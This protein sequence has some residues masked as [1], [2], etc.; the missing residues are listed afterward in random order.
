MSL[1][2]GIGKGLEGA[3]QAIGAGLAQYARMLQAEDFE[4]MR[5]A[6]MEKRWAIEDARYARREARDEQRYKDT[7]ERQERMDARADSRELRAESRQAVTMLSKS[8]DR[9]DSMKAD[10]ER[11]IREMFTDPMTKQITDAAGYQAAMSALNTSYLSDAKNMVTRSGLTESEA[12]QYGFG[13]Y[14]GGSEQPALSQATVSPPTPEPT[15]AQIPTPQPAFD[16]GSWANST[17]SNSQESTY[18]QMLRSNGATDEQIRAAMPLS[19]DKMRQLT[20]DQQ[21]Q[22]YRARSE[23]D[24]KGLLNIPTSDQNDDSFFD[25]VKR[26]L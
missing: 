23:L 9:L 1:L 16:V 4:R 15:P 17:R 26:V 10:K 24:Q 14:L 3:G 22:R 21:L 13:M 6:S 12:N 2:M 19:I 11:Q 5:Q 18:A 25:K 8:L 20:P 7:V